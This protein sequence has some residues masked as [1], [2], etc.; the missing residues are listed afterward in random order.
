MPINSKNRRRL[1]WVRL[2][3]QV[4]E[5]A[6]QT[7]K[8]FGFDEKTQGVVVTDVEPGSAASESGL[9]NGMLILKADQQAVTS[10]ADLQKV[11]EKASLEKGCLLQVRTSQGGTSYVLLKSQ[12]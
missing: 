7:A 9:K 8:Q 11:V 12:A 5:L 6:P 3:V 10:V 2:G 4:E 1:P